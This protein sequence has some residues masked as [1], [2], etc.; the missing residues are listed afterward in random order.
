[1]AQVRADILQRL[2]VAKHLLAANSDQ[3]TPNSDAAAVAR[4]VLAAHDA[5]ELA[6]AAIAS[7]L[8]VPGLGARTYLTEYPSKIEAQTNTTVSGADFLKRL[9]AVRIDFKHLGVLPDA[10]TWFRVIDNTRARVDDWCRAYLNVALDDIDLEQLLADGKVKTLYEAAKGHHR[11]R[12][13]RDALEMLGRALFYQLETFLGGVTPTV[14]EKNTEDALMLAAFGVRPS[15]FLALQE[16]LPRVYFGGSL[17]WHTRAKG[18]EGNWTE[19]NVRFCLET[20]L[21][22]ALKIQHAPPVPRAVWFSS[23]FDDVITPKG[24]SADL[25]VYEYDRSQGQLLVR[26]RKVVR[27]LRNGERL[28]CEYSRTVAEDKP[29]SGVLQ[30]TVRDSA[31]R[32]MQVMYVE[33][34]AVEISAAPQEDDYA[35]RVC[36]HLF[37]STPAQA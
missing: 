23:V 29:T 9:N 13:Y 32:I 21:D 11:D 31:G 3:L 18:H 27:T 28:R 24:E 16:F 25:F 20:F 1:M 34:D 12:R 8:N 37:G 30:V 10:R 4:M 15:D 17:Y 26:G 22:L 2:L 5:A 7:H 6:I 36:P 33:P 14:G 35:R 19:A